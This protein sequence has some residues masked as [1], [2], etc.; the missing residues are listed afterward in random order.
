MS[1]WIVV[2]GFEAS[3]APAAAHDL[4]YTITSLDI[5]NPS[6]LVDAPPPPPHDAA[7]L[8]GSGGDRGFADENVAYSHWL[9][10]FL[11]PVAA[12]SHWAGKYLAVCDSDP[13]PVCPGLQAAPRKREKGDRLL[14]PDEARAAAKAGIT[15]YGLI[16]REGWSASLRNTK[17]GKPI[18]VQR[19][20]KLDSFYYMVPMQTE[21]SVPVLV[22]VDGRFGNYQQAARTAK[23]QAN[24]LARLNF[25]PQWAEKVLLGR[26]IDLGRRGRLTVCK[27]AFSLYPTLVW[28]PCRESMSPYIPFFMATVGDRRIYLR[29]DGQVFTKL[30]TRDRGN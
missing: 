4:T 13:S 24:A 18:L 30:H 11:Y 15:Q 26:K 5:H 17:P 25:D 22:N 28:K 16:K 27:E 2:R 9:S 3:A 12:S 7:D 21:K 19:I 23:T 14:T 29:V 20:D 8:C 6:P 10:A 1:H